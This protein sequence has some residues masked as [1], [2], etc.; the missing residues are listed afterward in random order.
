MFI[1]IIFIEIYT[2]VE[3]KKTTKKHEELLYMGE[4]QQFD[5]LQ[6]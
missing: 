1:E 5:Q 6:R 4:T 3:Q 2:F